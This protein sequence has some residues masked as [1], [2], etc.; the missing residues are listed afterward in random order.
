MWTVYSGQALK[1]RTRVLW[2][3]CLWDEQ[4]SQGEWSEEAAFEIG[5][6]SPSD[7]KASW[8]KGDYKVDPK[9][10]YPVDCFRKRFVSRNV[11]KARLYATACGVYEGC[12]NGSRIGNFV[13]APG[14]TDYKKRIQYQTY[15]ITELIKDGENELTFQLADGWYRGS[16][17]AWGL[18]NQY[19]TETKLLAQLELT[20]TDGSHE[21][22]VTDGSWEWSD[23]GPI[24]F[25]DNKDGEIVDAARE[26][27]Y[28]GKAQKTSCDV[29]PSASNNI[30]VTEHEHFAP[31]R[32]KT[33]AGK[34]LLDFG[35]NMAGY[36]HFKFH[37][38][39]TKKII[40]R[41]GEMLDE[42][43]ELTLKNVQCSNKKKTTP[44][45]RIVY[46]CKKGENEYKTR[47]AAFGFRYCE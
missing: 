4:D 47:F 29:I 26:P 35:Q 46:R 16:V 1:S 11:V 39:Q 36:I 41:F 20:M 44:L 17:G 3:V 31:V 33:P 30:P 10:R 9:K 19:G 37:A 38:E 32:T 2:K 25:A 5:L 12:I 8:I 21:M 24:R 7:W 28:S 6:L 23:D 43:G 45:Q 34:L 15:D 42:N 14:V 40:L 22:I 18:V 13:L 27:S